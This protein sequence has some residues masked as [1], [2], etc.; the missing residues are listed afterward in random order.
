MFGTYSSRSGEILECFIVSSVAND[1]LVLS[2]YDL[3]HGIF[4]LVTHQSELT[5]NRDINKDLT[6]THCNEQLVA[7]YYK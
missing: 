3:H 7:Q 4:L 6:I 2:Q 1:C 5:Q